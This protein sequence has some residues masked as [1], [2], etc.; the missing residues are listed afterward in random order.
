MNV[1]NN[2]DDNANKN[3]MTYHASEAYHYFDLVRTVNFNICKIHWVL[4][5][6]VLY[7]LAQI[8]HAV[9]ISV[10][11]FAVFSLNHQSIFM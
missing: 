7:M 5:M 1:D 6:Y 8:V 9:R 11:V 4:C 10:N 3:N 2:I